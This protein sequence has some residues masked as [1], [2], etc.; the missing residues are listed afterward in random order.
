M[1]RETGRQDAGLD[2]E[3]AWR[4]QPKRVSTH[5]K[6]TP[7]PVITC[8]TPWSAIVVSASA[9]GGHRG[10]DRV[11]GSVRFPKTA[12]AERPGGQPC[13]ASDTPAYPDAG[14]DS[15]ERGTGRKLTAA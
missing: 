6:T 7:H 4:G 15:A 5:G 13:D 3:M 10:G 14:R 1:R 11:L 12:T 2:E 9:A 8:P